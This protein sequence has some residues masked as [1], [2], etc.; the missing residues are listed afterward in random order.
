MRHSLQA[1]SCENALMSSHVTEKAV[2]EANNL[3]L[4][5]SLTLPS[6]EYHALLPSRMARLFEVVDWPESSFGF[7]LEDST[8]CYLP[9]TILL[10]SLSGST[11][12]L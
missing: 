8:Y 11:Y 10:L 1:P 3:P 7:S 6:P 12:C 2:A 4:L 9:T 5:L